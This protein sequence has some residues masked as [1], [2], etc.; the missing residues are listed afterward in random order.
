[1]KSVTWHPM[2][3]YT[4]SFMEE[5]ELRWLQPWIPKPKGHESKPQGGEVA[6]YGDVHTIS[7]PKAD[8]ASQETQPFLT[9][10]KVLRPALLGGHNS[11]LLFSSSTLGVSTKHTNPA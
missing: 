9:G 7:N 2:R 8:R 11:C 10:G 1:M 5:G 3:N 6:E 4:G